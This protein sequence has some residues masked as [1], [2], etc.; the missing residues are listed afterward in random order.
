[1]MQEL[2]VICLDCGHIVVTRQETM[3]ENLLCDPA[4]VGDGCLP[5]FQT[6]ASIVM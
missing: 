6:W 1:M 3:S 5:C 2:L 4:A